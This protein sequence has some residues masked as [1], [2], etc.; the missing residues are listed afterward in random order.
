MN[1]RKNELLIYLII[2]LLIAALIFIAREF[3]NMKDE[4]ALHPASSLTPPNKKHLI[5]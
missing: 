4:S 3:S 5:S 1:N 2:I